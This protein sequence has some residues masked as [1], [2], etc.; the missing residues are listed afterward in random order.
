MLFHV[1]K[2]DL[3][4]SGIMKLETSRLSYDRNAATI[5][6]EPA[7]Q[8]PTGGTLPPPTIQSNEAHVDV[9]RASKIL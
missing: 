1:Q 7:L 2:V 6:T 3:C 8:Q 4:Q 9:A 5:S